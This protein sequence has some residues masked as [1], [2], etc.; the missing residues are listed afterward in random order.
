M[1]ILS[2]LALSVLVLSSCGGSEKVA[3]TEDKIVTPATVTSPENVALNEEISL[4][5]TST[6]LLKVGIKAPINGYIQSSSVKLGQAVDKG[7]TLFILKTKEAQSL[8]NTINKLDS[9]F[10]FSGL[11]K[12]RSPV[13]GF[14]SQ[15]NHQSGDYVQDGEQL[16]MLT[17]K[18]SFGFL[19][20]LPYE[21]NQLLAKNKN[22]NIHLPDGRN[23]AGFVV[24][25]MPALDS[26]T[27]TQQVL[28][29]VSSQISLPEN[30]IA[31]IFLTKSTSS[32]PSLPK[33]SVLSDESQQQFWVM[34]MIDDS[35]AVKIPVKKGIENDKRIE[36]LSPKFTGSEKI[37]LTGN[38]GLT[39]TAFVKIK[40]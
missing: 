5:A 24:Q 2:I 8:G 19:M 14:I 20:N 10:N 7:S 30:L 15:L 38:Y 33:E 21:Y 37:L 40:H 27:Q 1:K 32:F 34:K 25:I 26:V 11:N 28:I 12:V 29:K 9:S 36:I 22:V 6:Y 17:D 35:T 18:S 16:A 23:I 4:S 13:S 3:T 31:N 39:D